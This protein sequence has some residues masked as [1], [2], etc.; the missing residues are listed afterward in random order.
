MCQ[1]GSTELKAYRSKGFAAK[2]C[3]RC[4]FLGHQ[5][6][7]TAAQEEAVERYHVCNG[8]C[9]L[10]QPIARGFCRDCQ[11]VAN[12]NPSLRTK[13]NSIRAEQQA[14][15]RDDRWNK[16]LWSG[17]F[18]SLDAKISVKKA[19]ED[20][21]KTLAATAAQALID[22]QKEEHNLL[23]ILQ[24]A[25]SGKARAQGLSTAQAVAAKVK[26]VKLVKTAAPVPTP[27]PTAPATT[28]VVILHPKMQTLAKPVCHPESLIEF[29]TL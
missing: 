14:Q 6:V 26:T 12:V 1:C 10:V 25:Q 13:L 3:I 8:I 2:N 5:D 16:T 17:A 28:P 22:E 9:G 24:F 21:E 4:I 7:R 29:P 19:A 18:A 23:R 27:A 15:T 20:A 11:A